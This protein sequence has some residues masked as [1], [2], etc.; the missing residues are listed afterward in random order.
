MWDIAQE[1]VVED[2]KRTL[3]GRSATYALIARLYEKEADQALLDEMFKLTYPVSSGNDDLDEGYYAMAKFLS[4]M[5]AET[6]EELRRDYARCFISQGLDSF[7]AAY[8]YESVYTSED[9]LIMQDAR[10]QVLS[11]YHSCGFEK[12]EGNRECED[13]VAMELQFM[14]MMNDR[15]LAKLEDGDQDGAIYSLLVQKNF[16]SDHL[17]SW[18]PR[19]TADIR[20]FAESKFYQALACITDGF[21][22]M[23][24]E[25][26]SNLFA[27][28]E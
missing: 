7:S 13:H 12:A 2:L 20:C 21:L 24:A 11:V 28:E 4:N 25:F 1:Q 10:D 18:T 22:A 3:E 19:F 23:D 15:A 8:P 5:W 16:L 9:R 27:V 6:V 17:I 14:R 26:L